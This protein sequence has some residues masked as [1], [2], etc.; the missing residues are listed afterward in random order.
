MTTA[1]MT[2]G[3]PAIRLFGPF[4][5]RV[6][7]EPLLE[8]CVEEWVFAE[9]ET[10]EQAFLQALE[11]LAQHAMEGEHPQA[12]ALH[13]RRVVQTDPLRESAQRGLMHAL[14][15]QGDHAAVTQVYRD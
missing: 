3:P 2:T 9:R 8:G 7:G 12:A 1:P 13:L 5:V 6:N 4:E 15:A 11:A 14:A 10:R